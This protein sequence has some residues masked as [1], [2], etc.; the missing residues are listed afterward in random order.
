MRNITLDALPDRSS[1]TLGYPV[2]EG[3]AKTTLYYPAKD[4]DTFSH[5]AYIAS[6]R[7]ILYASWSN[8]A[9]DEDAS[10][11]RVRFSF[12]KDDGGSWHEPAELFPP[13]DLVKPRAE[14]DLARDRVLIA[15]GFAVVEG[16]LYAVAEAHVMGEESERVLVPPP[17]YDVRR[18]K[19]RPVWTRPGLGRLARSIGTGGELGPIFWLVDQPPA[20]L[21]GF[22]AYPPA[23]DPTFAATAR[24]I[25]AYLARPEH[26]P[27]WEFVNC[28]TRAWAVDGH[29]MCEPT[30]A[31]H[32]P[33]GS[34]ARLWRDLTRGSGVQY[35]QFSADGD[36]WDPPFPSDVPGA[37]TRAAAG[38]LPDGTAYLVHNPGQGRDPLVVSLAADGLHFDRHGVIAHN[39]P[40]HRYEGHAKNPG[41]QYPRAVI[42]NDM[43]FA[44]YSVNKEHMEIA[45]VPLNKLAT[46]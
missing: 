22:E 3:V 45:A 9:R 13:Q 16:T 21:P 28:T 35:G 40:E 30:Q 37:Y 19:L 10:G 33:D 38:N 8:H 23:T 4:R 27:S 42:H 12:S 44:L 24:A 14:Q 29:R 1:P 34:M 36:H 18:P 6:H 15:N 5:H 11:Q 41:F 7:G 32:L 17:E 39:A 43:L 31:W 26:W 46:L 20:P 25:N 2:L